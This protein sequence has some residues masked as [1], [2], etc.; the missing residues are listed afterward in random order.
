[1]VGALAACC[2]AMMNSHHHE[3]EQKNIEERHKQELIEA[4]NRRHQKILNAIN[5]VS[6]TDYDEIAPKIDWI[7]EIYGGV[8][9][10]TDQTN[11]FNELLNYKLERF[12]NK[13][14]H[15]NVDCFRTT[16]LID[17][18]IEKLLKDEIESV[19]FDLFFF[20]PQQIELI[21]Q[22]MYPIFSSYGKRYAGYYSMIIGCFWR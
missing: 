14:S 19:S 12:I 4:E 1:M 13:C 21:K 18:E 9:E 8:I 5:G 20:E 22:K 17:K 3:D 11:Q 16:D 7:F 15:I 2:G 10:N 6:T